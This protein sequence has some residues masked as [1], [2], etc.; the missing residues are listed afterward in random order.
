MPL[1]ARVT[2]AW[3]VPGRSMTT[4]RGVRGGGLGAG[5]ETGAAGAVQ[6]PNSRSARAKPCAGSMSPVRTSTALSG[7]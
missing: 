2:E 6:S 7:R 3:P 5:T 4:T 1:K